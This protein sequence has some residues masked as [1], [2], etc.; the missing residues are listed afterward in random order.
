MHIERGSYPDEARF[1]PVAV[2]VLTSA[3][4]NSTPAA[5]VE[6]QLRPLRL[7]LLRYSL[8]AYTN[9]GFQPLYSP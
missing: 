7:N 4:L 6:L 2:Q 1:P 9:Q 5:G 3:V 8:I